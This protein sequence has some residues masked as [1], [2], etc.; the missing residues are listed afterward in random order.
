MN[1][2]P[3]V[4]AEKGSGLDLKFDE[5]ENKTRPDPTLFPIED[6][7]RGAEVSIAQVSYTSYR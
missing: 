2:G 7:S 1:P 4:E 6:G 5:A 3:V